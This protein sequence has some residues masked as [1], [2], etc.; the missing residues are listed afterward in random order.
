VVWMAGG[1]GVKGCW[2]MSGWKIRYEFWWGVQ[3]RV[4]KGGRQRRSV[5][6]FRRFRI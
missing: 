4:G 6:K 3:S 2:G 5:C 1:H